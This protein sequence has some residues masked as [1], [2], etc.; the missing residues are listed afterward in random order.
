MV[1]WLPLN[2]IQSIVENSHNKNKYPG[3]DLVLI[4]G[5]IYY[6]G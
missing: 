2:L 4:G 1:K 6:L 5:V 3:S